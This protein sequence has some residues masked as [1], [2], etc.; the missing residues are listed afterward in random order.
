MTIKTEL[1]SSDTHRNIEL[2]FVKTVSMQTDNSLHKNILL[3]KKNLLHLSEF[4]L[5]SVQIWKYD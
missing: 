1:Q 3:K 5:D 4:E 2:K